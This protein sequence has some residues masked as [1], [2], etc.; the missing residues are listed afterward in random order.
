MFFR[1][2]ILIFS[3]CLCG[4]CSSEKDF[5]ADVEGMLQKLDRTIHSKSKFEEDKV[6]YVDHL[7][8]QFSLSVEKQNYEIC[9]ALYNEYFAYNID[10]ANLYANRKMELAK[11]LHRADLLNDALLDLADRY[12][13]SGM[14][15][16]ADSLIRQI[17][18]EELPLLLRP[19]YYH[20]CH[21]YYEGMMGNSVDLRLRAKYDS[22]RVAYRHELYS[23]LGD[24]D[25]A[26]LWIR[27]E[28]LCEESQA[29]EALEELLEHD[30]DENLAIHE[31]AILSYLTATA[32]RQTG[33]NERAIF[34][35][36]QAAICDL[37]TPVFEYRSLYELAS[38][39]YEAGHI[40]RAYEYIT[41]SVRD[42]IASNAR[43][44]IRSINK[45][46]P[47]ISSSY[48]RQ[49]ALKQ[50]QLNHMLI[51][52]SVLSLLVVVAAGYSYREKQRANRT[53]R[54]TYEA[55]EKLRQV[56]ARLQKYIGLMQES[57]QIK[58]SYLGRYLD[59]CSD[60]IGRLEMY[61]LEINRAAR[62]GGMDGVK[63]AL[64]S[65]RFIESELDEFYAQFD[66]TFL[67]LFPDFVP[68][69]NALLQPEKRVAIDP[70]NALLTT[71]LRIFALIRLGIGDSVKISKFLRRSVSTI[72][73]YRVKM[74]NAALVGRE[75]FEKQVMRIGR[76]S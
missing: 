35:Y 63:K 28:R 33:N 11:A 67:H 52:V 75:D 72:Y 48:N 30:G 55:Y 45:I 6:R 44:N 37:E 59:L 38:M 21:A 25:I 19:R 32:Y 56:N 14:Y 61:R 41:C 40:R 47:I 39:L 16:E 49:M 5:P 29:E 2:V 65:T 3:V 73:N 20:V 70:S 54:K 22:L 64:K 31:R 26:G 50:R 76:L 51:G 43:A 53:E 10:S 34:Y 62:E 23:R 36:A 42:A 46:L 71:E 13:L 7:K 69:F 12:I 66:A 27:S 57:D 24:D 58:E 74:R 4:S 68:Q 8:S 9:D 15:V 60:Y 1:W 17:D 18:P